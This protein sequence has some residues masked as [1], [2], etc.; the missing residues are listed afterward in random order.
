VRDIDRSGAVQV[1]SGLRR[2]ACFTGPV[3]G[4]LQSARAGLVREQMS[5][6]LPEGGFSDPAT[7]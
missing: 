3:A 5:W 1:G 6:G 2:G 4:T 7:S